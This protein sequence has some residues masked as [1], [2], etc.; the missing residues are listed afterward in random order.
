VRLFLV[1]AHV[2]FYGVAPFLLR[3]IEIS[4]TSTGP[5]SR[6]GETDEGWKKVERKRKGKGKEKEGVERKEMS[7]PSWAGK[8]RGRG[9]SVTVFTGM[10]RE[11]RTQTQERLGGEG[12]RKEERACR[13]I[14]DPTGYLCTG[15]K[16]VDGAAAGEVLEV[17]DRKRT[18][19]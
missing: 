1:T 15:T 12:V 3:E 8:A 7:A 4:A 19:R 11:A 10:N 18:G 2:T 13:P 6:H 14:L 5:A 16:V 17:A 9:V